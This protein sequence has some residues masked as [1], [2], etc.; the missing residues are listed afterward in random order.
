MMIA[1]LDVPVK[2][3][4][5]KGWASFWKSLAKGFGNIPFNKMSPGMAF[6]I[7]VI[8]VV[9]VFTYKFISSN[10]D[11]TN[12]ILILCIMLAFCILLATPFII[13]ECIKEV[14][15]IKK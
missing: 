9:L 8:I 11:G 2:E 14:K 12:N 10:P 5:N 6:A 4:G 15:K 3:D 13:I 7:L 1:L